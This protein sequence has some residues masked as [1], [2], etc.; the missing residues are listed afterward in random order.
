MANVKTNSTAGPSQKVN[1]KKATVPRGV[2]KGGRV[3]KTT[4]P[5]KK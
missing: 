3:W 5:A 2:P 4:T 1:K